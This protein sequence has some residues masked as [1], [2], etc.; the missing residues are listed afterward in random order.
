[1]LHGYLAIYPSLATLCGQPA[2]VFPVGLAPDGLPVG[3]QV[4]GPYL[5][6]HTPLR[7]AALVAERLGGY[8]PP[9]SCQ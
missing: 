7:F 1:M 8:Q 9:P 4:I 6:D 3:L 2:T 5:E